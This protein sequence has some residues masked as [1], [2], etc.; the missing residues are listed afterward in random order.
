[1]HSFEYPNRKSQKASE[2]DRKLVVLLEGM[3]KENETITARGLVKFSEGAI[4]NASD[5]TRDNWRNDRLGEWAKRQ[6]E[7]RLL[8]EK[9]DKTSR[10]NLQKQLAKK[11]ARIE[12]LEEQV[13]LL[14]ASHKAMFLSV[15]ENGGMKAWLRFFE[16]HQ[17]ALK[18]L[19]GWAWN[20]SADAP[21][22]D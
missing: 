5:I 7:M 2:L 15:G 6:R 20:Q 12:E 13:Q 19:K 4:K 17:E 16:D 18:A 21:I 8:M 9:A 10:T 3:L 11:Q 22:T 1:M 14:L